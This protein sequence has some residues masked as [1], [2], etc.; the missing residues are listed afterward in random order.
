VLF[1]GGD[2]SRKGGEDLLEAMKS[3]G[4][5]AELDVVT[6]VRPR[7]IPT[8]SPT[9]VHLGLNH[10]SDELFELFRQADIFV[11]PTIGET[12]GLVICEAMAS[13]LPVVATNVGAIPEI[14]EDGVSGVLVPPNSPSALA[15]SL[16][17]LVRQP[18]ERRSMG[19]RGLQLA[20]RDHDA[21]RNIESILELM[22]GL[23]GSGRNGSKDKR[24]G[25]VPHRWKRKTT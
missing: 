11:L 17:R 16:Q 15:D 9:R 10:A 25:P 3:L 23:S 6:G 12:Y 22:T 24:R 2:F 21:K 8:S 20:H 13:G 18:E 5:E 14:V 4:D 7:S 1:V 19:E